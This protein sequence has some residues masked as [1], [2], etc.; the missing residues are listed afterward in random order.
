MTI[1]RDADKP[2]VIER[3]A[4]LERRGIDAESRTVPAALSTD[5]PIRREGW[6][7]PY[8][9][10][11]SHAEGAIDLTRAAEGLPLLFN[12][13]RSAPIG[14]VRDVRLEGG[15]LRGVLHFSRNARASE[16]WQDVQDGMLRDISVS[17][18]ILAAD[19]RR[20]N[21]EEKAA[22]A[23]DELV[24]EQWAIHEASVVTVP[25]DASAGIFRSEKEKSAMSEKEQNEAGTDKA[26]QGGDNADTIVRFEQARNSGQKLGV[27]AERARMREI[28]EIYR[29]HMDR[30][31]VADLQVEAEDQGWSVERAGRELLALLGG[32]PEP[33]AKDSV[34]R[35]GY[36]RNKSIKPGEDDAEKFMR[37]LELALM[38]R[39]GN[40][41]ML[42]KETG[43]DVAEIRREAEQSEFYGMS[44]V[45]QARE[46]MKRAGEPLRG[47]DRI[48]IAGQAFVSR[49]ILPHGAGSFSNLTANVANK[50]L[51]RGFMEADTSW[52]LLVRTMEVPD[53][54]TNSLLTLT[55]ATDL[56]KLAPSG[57][58]EGLDI[59]DLK[60]TITLETY[61]GRLGLSRKALVDDDMNELD[62]VPA[63]MGMAAQRNI[64][65]IVLQKILNGITDT[66]VQD[67]GNAV[68]SAA[69]SNFVAGGSG[70]A[71]SVTTLDAART[72]MATQTDP[73]TGA[74][75][76]IRW[77]SQNPAR[78]LV[79]AALE[80]SSN[81]LQTSSTDPAQTSKTRP[82]PNPF[83]GRFIVVSNAWID[84]GLTGSDAAKWFVFADPAIWDG[85]VVA[86]LA[87]RRAPT[88]ETQNAWSTLGT[89]LRVYHDVAVSWADYRATYHNDGN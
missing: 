44:R 15:K 47:L 50:S 8:T 55:G 49:S 27:E 18:P 84:S 54:K 56:Q 70:A 42:A 3:A 41:D 7:G 88:I 76:N 73:K 17:G 89:E 69:H 83:Q 45:E 24:I 33:I 38:V 34:Q 11:L 31:G 68:Y 14:V 72:A 48:G 21:D 26:G 80:T 63:A 23:T 79:P 13:D 28:R 66:L 1:K 37:G 30:D 59:G 39:A 51:L 75:L 35:D 62:R 53:F 10:R 86:F 2:Q 57:E 25:A 85:L 65:K 78:L 77:T 87:G 64:G 12:H 46:Y 40:A 43:R 29:A 20:A 16:I 60:E 52:E 4:T 58:I 67:S 81:V 9:E 36:S 32:N 5:T 19:F 74:P 61:A 6:D 71:P 22:G 82:E